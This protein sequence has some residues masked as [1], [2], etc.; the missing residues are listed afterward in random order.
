VWLANKRGAMTRTHKT[1]KS[2]HY[3]NKMGDI[4]MDA[5]GELIRAGLGDLN[6][7]WLVMPI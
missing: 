4:D 2:C 5:L 1:G 3:V 7:R 6:E